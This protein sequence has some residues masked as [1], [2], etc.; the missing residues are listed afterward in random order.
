M[1]EILLASKET[2]PWDVALPNFSDS[3]FQK[4][5]ASWASLNL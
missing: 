2:T 5:E 3:V 1:M 4:E